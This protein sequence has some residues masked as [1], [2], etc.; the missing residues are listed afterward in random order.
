M[1]DSACVK[2]LGASHN[3]ELWEAPKTLNKRSASRTD[4]FRTPV[5]AGYV[6]LRTIGSYRELLGTVMISL[7][8]LYPAVSLSQSSVYIDVL[9]FNTTHKP[10][11]GEL[12]PLYDKLHD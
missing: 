10:L 1:H 3:S 7:H 9:L 2:V 4:C 11:V 12:H 8:L 6:S 5:I